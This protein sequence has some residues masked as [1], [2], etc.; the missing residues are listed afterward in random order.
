MR[1]LTAFIDSVKA[2][3]GAPK[4]AMIALSRGGYATRDYVAAASRERQACA[5]LGGTPNNGVWATDY[6]ARQR[7]QRPRP[8]L[9][10]LEPA[11]AK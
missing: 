6:T 7:I 1:E 10:K 9:T 3:T 8:F 4:V 5:A 2:K 11:T